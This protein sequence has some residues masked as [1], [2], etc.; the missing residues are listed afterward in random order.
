MAEELTGG[1]DA[2]SPGAAVKAAPVKGGISV[3]GNNMLDSTQTEQLLAQM[4]ELINQRSQKDAFQ[5]AA[6]NIKAIGA[7][8]YQERQTQKNQE[9]QDLFNMRAQMAAVRGSQ[10]MT[11]NQQKSIDHLMGLGAAG[12]PGQQQ[13]QTGAPGQ[14]QQ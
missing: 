11:Q 12:A 5:E 13:Q 9:A 14:Q 8:K 4:Q 2:I 3:P 1:L 7:G 6:E 10:A